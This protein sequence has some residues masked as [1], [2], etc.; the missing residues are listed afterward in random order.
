MLFSLLDAEVRLDDR[1]L[2]AGCRQLSVRS[3]RQSSG[4]SGDES[5]VVFVRDKPAS[6]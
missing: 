6:D 5:N 2:A 4:S 3:D 1:R